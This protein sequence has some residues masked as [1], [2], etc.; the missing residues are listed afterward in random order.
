MGKHAIT[1]KYQ[2]QEAKEF[3]LTKRSKVHRQRT[4]Q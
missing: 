4:N 3:K 2:I 1:T